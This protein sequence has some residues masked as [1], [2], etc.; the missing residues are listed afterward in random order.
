LGYS[1]I[2]VLKLH[3]VKDLKRVEIRTLDGAHL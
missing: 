1:W 3:V 2:V